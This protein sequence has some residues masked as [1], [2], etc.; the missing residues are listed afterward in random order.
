MQERLIH[1]L[2]K[3]YEYALIREDGCLDMTLLKKIAKHMEPPHVYNSLPKADKFRA[4]LKS[5]GY[6]KKIRVRPYRWVVNEFSFLG[7]NTPH[8]ALQ[9]TFE[10]GISTAIEKLERDIH[11]KV[12]TI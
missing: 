4:I 9:P 7:D 12:I 10:G 8:N 6:D 11:Q 3:K 5:L 2:I 1:L